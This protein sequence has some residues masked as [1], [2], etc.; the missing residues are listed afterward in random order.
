VSLSRDTRNEKKLKAIRRAEF[1]LKQRARTDRLGRRTTCCVEVDRVQKRKRS[2]PSCPNETIVDVKFESVAQ[3]EEMIE[4]TFTTRPA[5]ELCFDLENMGGAYWFDGNMTA[6]IT[7]I[8]WKWLGRAGVHTLL[9]RAMAVHPGWEHDDGS[10]VS[11]GGGVHCGSRRTGPVRL[12]PGATATTSASS[13][14]RC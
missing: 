2:C 14:C 5:R 11:A 10:T 13:T 6:I 3:A 1:A 12:R 9:L 8:G 4:V 7:A